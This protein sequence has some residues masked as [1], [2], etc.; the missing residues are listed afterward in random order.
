MLKSKMQAQC[1]GSEFEI[2]SEGDGG[3][4]ICRYYL[5][6][7]SRAHSGNKPLQATCRRIKAPAVLR[8]SLFA[9]ESEFSMK[10]RTYFIDLIQRVKL[11]AVRSAGRMLEEN[12]TNRLS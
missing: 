3:F 4:H 6:S 2:C 1:S 11:A 8:L 12:G 5:L 10:G 9:C 7:I